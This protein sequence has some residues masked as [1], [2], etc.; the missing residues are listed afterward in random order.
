MAR[1][2]AINERSSAWTTTDGDLVPAR[3]IVVAAN[4]L[5]I[6]GNCKVGVAATYTL[7]MLPRESRSAPPIA[8]NWLEP[9][10]GG[11]S[12]AANNRSICESASELAPSS[13]SMSRKYFFQLKDEQTGTGKVEREKYISVF[14]HICISIRKKK[15]KHLITMLSQFF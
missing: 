11:E 2:S 13:F 14:L 10:F 9:L 12:R 15:T 8:T 4:W 6:A 7:G 5:C 3:G 1:I